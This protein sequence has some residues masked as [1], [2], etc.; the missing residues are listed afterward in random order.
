MLYALSFNV[1]VVW[2][3]SILWDTSYISSPFSSSD[4]CRS[5]RDQ[6]LA[7]W[8][9]VWVAHQ[10]LQFLPKLG[11]C[12]SVSQLYLTLCDPKDCS[13]PSFPTLFIISRSSLKLMSIELVPTISSSVIRF[14]SC[15]QSFS[16]SGSFLMSWLFTS[17]YWPCIGVSAS[18][19]VLPIN[20]YGWFPLGL[21]GL[22]FLQSK[23]LSRVSPT[24]QFKRINSSVLS[25]LYGPT[26]TSIHDYWKNHTFDYTD[27]CWQCLCF[28]TRCIKATRKPGILAMTALDLDLNLTSLEINIGFLPKHCVTWPSP[29]GSFSIMSI[30]A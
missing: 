19:S 30:E 1:Q 27:L 29:W 15:L 3:Y 8:G 24:P 14:S 17:E 13:M 20:I 2:K 28:L 25:L 9:S 16:A 21:T 23:G 6:Y 18:A 11:I 22:I 5:S 7:L 26:L 12:C 10:N 4:L